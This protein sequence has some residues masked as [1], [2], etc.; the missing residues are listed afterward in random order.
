MKIEAQIGPTQDAIQ[1]PK[2]EM[3]ILILYTLIQLDETLSTRIPDPD[4]FRLHLDSEKYCYCC[5]KIIL[6]MSRREFMFC[7]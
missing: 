5:Y 1:I 3:I 7:F 4:E 2:Q 6:I